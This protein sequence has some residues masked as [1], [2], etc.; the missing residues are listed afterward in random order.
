MT[1]TALR[2]GVLGAANIA[3]QFIAG[4]A[5]SASVAVTAVA[6]RDAAKGRAFARE[7]GVARSYGSYEALLADPAI[8]A[9][10]NP[11][12][13]SLH[14]QWS[15]RAAEAG[16]HV[17]CE[18]PLAVTAAEARA[19]FAAARAHGVHVV[20]AYPYLAQPQTRK[21]RDLL[22]DGAIGRMRHIQASLGFRVDTP[23]NIRLVA[24]LGGG[25]RL[26][27]GSYPLSLARVLAGE[28]PARVHALARWASEGVEQ[29]LAA[30]LEFPDGMI[31]QIACSFATGYH[32]HALISGDSGAIMTNYFNH[33]PQGGTLTLQ[34]K[35]SPEFDAP[36]ESLE[37]PG[38]NGFLAEA[39]SF[40][41]LVAGQP[42][43]W[44]GATPEESIDIMLTLDAIAESAR[45]GAAVDVGA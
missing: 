39:E 29:T 36:Y 3:R 45:S 17:L 1:P 27:A 14:A 35:R 28:R 13:N 23:D 2:I 31:A 22:R 16:K 42:D 43:L 18:K 30:T 37:L 11:L 24:A 4:V 9:I 15:I 6:S 7:V 33:A 12:P 20:E 41:R 19:M 26:D 40:A 5:P 8:D 25:A 38:G 10:Y 32:R 44:T 21:L 34:V